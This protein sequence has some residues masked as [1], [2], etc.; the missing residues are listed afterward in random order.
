MLFA[1]DLWLTGTPNAFCFLGVSTAALVNESEEMKKTK[2]K[3]I[4]NDAVSR[5]GA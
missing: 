1:S 3:R 2:A 4:A 5:E